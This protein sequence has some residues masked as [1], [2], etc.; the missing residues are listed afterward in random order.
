[1]GNYTEVL[2][3]ENVNIL[4]NNGVKQ[5]ATCIL[6]SVRFVEAENLDWR[7]F[8]VSDHR[9]R[10]SSPIFGLGLHLNWAMQ[11]IPYLHKLF[12]YNSLLTPCYLLPM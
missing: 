12:T 2:N 10:K 3:L 9:F 4:Y 1:M 8:R 5:V 11:T 6:V 7:L